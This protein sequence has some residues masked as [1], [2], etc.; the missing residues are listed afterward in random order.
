MLENTRPNQARRV[1]IIQNVTQVVDGANLHHFLGI[2]ATFL[3]NLRHFSWEFT[4]FGEKFT[5]IY[6][7]WW[8]GAETS[9]NPHKLSACGGGSVC[10]FASRVAVWSMPVSMSWRTSPRL[11][12]AKGAQVASICV[13]SWVKTASRSWCPSRVH[14][15]IA[16]V[17]VL[18]VA[19][20]ASGLKPP[21]RSSLATGAW[22]IVMRP[23]AG[24]R[25]K[26][27]AA[28]TLSLTP[29]AP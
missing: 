19:A 22:S 18:R 7:T 14:M 3:G 5:P 9:V 10:Q 4:P 13:R 28:K 27:W 24:L 11:P 23:P 17:A 6:T 29:V 21:R 16:P 25:R 12:V 8:T 1:K 2:Y 26:A 20:V 15:A